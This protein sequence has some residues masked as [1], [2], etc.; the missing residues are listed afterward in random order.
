METSGIIFDQMLAHYGPAKLTL[1]ITQ[2]EKTVFAQSLYKV[3]LDMDVC[4]HI[5]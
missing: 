4:V 1:A 3:I 5:V 2:T